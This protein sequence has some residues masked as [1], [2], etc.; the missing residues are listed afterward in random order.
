VRVAVRPES[1]VL[2]RTGSGGLNGRVVQSVFS[3]ASMIM[4][5]ETREGVTMQAGVSPHS[6]LAHLQ[7]GDTVAVKWNARDAHSFA[8]PAA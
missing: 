6:D 5:I 4:L 2:G 7:P 3:G 8:R 1:L